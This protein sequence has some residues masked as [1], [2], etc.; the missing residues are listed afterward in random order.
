ME[1]RERTL[2]AVQRTYVAAIAVAAGA[3]LAAAKRY[4]RDGTVL[5]LVVALVVLAWAAADAALVARMAVGGAGRLPPR[6][7]VALVLGLALTGLVLIAG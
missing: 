4:Q 1:A 6:R 3:V 7:A 2:F 5:P